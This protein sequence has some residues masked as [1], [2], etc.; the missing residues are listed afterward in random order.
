MRFQDRQ[1][2][3]GKLVQALAGYRGQNPLVLAVPRGAVPMG[4]VIADAL[5]GELDVVLVRKLGAPGNPELAVGS[6]DEGGHMYIAEHARAMGISDSYL[7]HEKQAQIETMRQ[8]R[9]QYTPVRAPINPAGRVVIVVDDGLATG[10]TMIAALRAVR[11]RKPKKLIAAVAVAPPET[12][13]RMRPEA[14]DVVCLHA[15][16][17]FYAVGQFFVD[18]P[19]VSDTEV[20]ATLQSGDAN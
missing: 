8:R 9:A 13:V 2:A 6:V 5:D 7:E 12:L 11:A 1:E 14:D 18:F 10:S 3:A 20:I 16:E 15:P 19:Q 4:R 17:S